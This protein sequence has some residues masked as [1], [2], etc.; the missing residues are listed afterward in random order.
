[1][2]NFSNLELDNVEQHITEQVTNKS[3]IRL[4]LTSI[5]KEHGNR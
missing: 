3:K 4:S 2:I 5:N 1:L